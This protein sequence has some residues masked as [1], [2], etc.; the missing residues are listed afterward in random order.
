MNNHKNVMAPVAYVIK[1]RFYALLN[2]GVG[3]IC[4]L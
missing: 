1:R 4:G 2:L 3:G